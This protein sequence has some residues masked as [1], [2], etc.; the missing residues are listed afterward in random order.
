[1]GPPR[2]GVGRS[3]ARKG[4]G[5]DFLVRTGY[6]DTYSVRGGKGI[7]LGNVIRRGKEIWLSNFKHLAFNVKMIL[8]FL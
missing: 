5:I 7:Q 2:S 8:E 6:R 1:M 4:S 3:H